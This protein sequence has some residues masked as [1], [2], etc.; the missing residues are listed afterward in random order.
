MTPSNKLQRFADKLFG[1]AW[2][3]NNIL[4]LVFLSGALA[5]LMFGANVKAQWWVVDDH[6]IAYFLGSDHVLSAG[7]IP[8]RL[9]NDTEVGQYLQL[10]RF[11][12]VYYAFRLLESWAW[13]V[14]PGLWYAFR[15]FIFAAFVGLFWYLISQKVGSIIGGFIALYM[16]IQIYWV[17]VISRLGPSEIYAVLGLSL[18]GWGVHII[19]KSNKTMGWWCIF[20]GALICSGAKENF[21]FL[22]L[23]VAYIGWDFYKNGKLNFVRAALLF[24]ACVWMVWIGSTIVISTLSY[25]GDVYNN[26]VG[27]RDRVVILLQ[28]F[29]RIDVIVLLSICVFLLL[30]RRSFHVKGSSLL[31]SDREVVALAI[32]F[33]LIYISQIFIYN[34]E[35]PLGTRY[36]FPGLLVA[37][38]MLVVLI[39]FA[40]KITTAIGWVRF[41]TSLILISVFG[42]CL[43]GFL[44]LNRIREIRF[45]NNRNVERS[46]TFSRKM[47]QI[48]D[49]GIQNPDH[50]FIIQADNPVWDYEPIFSYFRFLRF[51]GA[52]N[53]IAFLWAGRKP[54][55]YNNEF[56]ISLASDLRDL[57]FYGKLPLMVAGDEHDFMPFSEV[58][59]S[60][61][62]CI[63]VLISGQ[64]K[65]NCPIV[66]AGNWR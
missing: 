2:N 46:V 13:G 6:E 43:L 28:L 50:A 61:T 22:I 66:V 10:P 4:L 38:L 12:P 56:S 32:I 41:R 23:P 47:E 48:A 1:M 33:T 53:R 27:M 20:A 49:L 34:G 21:L 36:D 18:F 51:Y 5:A 63:L 37:P 59:G 65:K 26:S 54:E 24:G 16:A 52:K 31:E 64:P 11:R 19:Y 45:L 14:R 58:D 57:S 42:T 3:K 39:A 15:I 9:L 55:T 60:E 29:G 62:K 17:D 40:Q 44:Q 30:L 25:G 8:E 35:W 7:E